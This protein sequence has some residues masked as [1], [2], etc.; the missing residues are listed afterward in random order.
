MIDLLE[1]VVLQFD[2]QESPE[3]KRS[4][5]EGLLVQRGL[6]LAETVPLFAHSSPCRCLPTMRLSPCRPSNRSRKR[7]TPF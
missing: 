1:R 2:H 6:Q 5:L 4:K 7:Y 3:Q